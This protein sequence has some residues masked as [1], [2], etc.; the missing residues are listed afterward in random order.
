MLSK[1]LLT[2]LKLQEWKEGTTWEFDWYIDLIFC[3]ALAFG[4]YPVKLN[5]FQPILDD[6]FLSTSSDKNTVGK[7][8]DF[9]HN[10]EAVSDLISKQKA[11]LTEAATVLAKLKQDINILDY[12]IYYKTQYDLSL[13]MAS[14]SVVFDKLIEYKVD[15]IAKSK[16]IQVERL[17]N[18]IIESS[19][20]TALNKSN[21]ELSALYNS[22]QKELDEY[23]A[24]KGTL[25][26]KLIKRL[27]EHVEKY[28]WINT[29]ERGKH[30]WNTE[31]FLEQLKNLL[32]STKSALEVLD[33][34]TKSELVNLIAININ[35]N[36]AADLQI[37]LD[38]LFQKHL[39]IILGDRYKEE[40]IERLSFD[41]IKE[42]VS[43]PDKINGYTLE[44]LKRHKLIYPNDASII[45]EILNE[46]DYRELKEILANDKTLSESI[47][48]RSACQGMAEGY[49][50]LVKN[51]Q[52]L[53]NFEE[54]YILVTEK[55]QPSYV[56]A[57]KKAKAIVTDIGGIT[58]HAAIVSRE[59]NIPCVVAT[60]NA[61]KQLKNGDFVRVDAFTGN[62]IKLNK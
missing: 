54:G 47:K 61:T 50:M 22:H 30:T 55:T 51:M 28:G 56:I 41:Q 59:F 1:E 31:D 37:E 40:I 21:E 49:V 46:T 60:R 39:R 29:G 10:T 57:M 14:V 48:G 53:E 32:N 4:T 25:S 7:F 34:T 35:D 8:I 36:V 19:S 6:E 2:I 45:E 9:F 17:S 42:I 33:D 11:I 18:Y 52:D 13:L 26:I 27:N 23:L 58:S 20:V 62:V 43:E 44:S 3:H 15:E 16:N 12:D 24:S 5:F 38:F